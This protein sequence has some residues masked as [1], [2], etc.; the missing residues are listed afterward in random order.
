MSSGWLGIRHLSVSGRPDRGHGCD[1]ARRHVGSTPWAGCGGHRSGRDRHR[2]RRRHGQRRKVGQC[3]SW[4]ECSHGRHRRGARYAVTL[5]E[6]GSPAAGAAASGARFPKDGFAELS[7]RE[8]GP[9]RVHLV[10]LIAGD[11]MPDLSAAN[12]EIYR[13]RLFAVYPTTAVEFT[14]GEPLMA[15]GTSMCALLSSVSSRRSADKAPVDVYYYGVTTGTSG[16]QSGCS[17]ASAS[18]SGSKTSAGWASSAGRVELG[19][20]TMCHEL[21]HAH[22]RQ[23]APCNVQDPDRVVIFPEEAQP[24]AAW[25]RLIVDSTGIHWGGDPLELQGTPEGTP[26][27]AVIHDRNGPM[28]STRVYREDLEDGVSESAFWLTVPEP[29]ANWYAIEVPGLLKPQAF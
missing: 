5:V 10:P 29:G 8:T 19:A 12:L 7:A 16:G 1:A 15:T 24:T 14:V 20:G 26:V 11:S 2:G 13:K 4:S 28:L 23:H 27:N 21:G 18:A 6:C 22:G 17:N 9:L 3:R 25:R